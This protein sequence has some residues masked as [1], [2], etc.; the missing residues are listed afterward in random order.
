MNKFIVIT[1]INAKSEGIARFAAHEDWNIIIVGDRK[2]QHIDSSDNIIFLSIEDQKK[3]GYQFLELCP[4]DHYA[5]KNIGYLYAIQ[6]DADV[7]FDTD[8][9]NLPYDNWCLP[10]FLCNMV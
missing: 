1:T 6:Q 9:D 3:L 8:D 4:Y 2:S 5:R 10:D 7:I